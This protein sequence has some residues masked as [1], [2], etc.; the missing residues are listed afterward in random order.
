MSNLNVRIVRLEPMRVASFYGFGKTPENEAHLSSQA[1]LEK[2]GLK[3]NKK[4]YRHFGFNNPDPSHGSPNYGYEIWI[5]VPDDYQDDGSA[6]IKDFSGGLFAVT[7]CEGLHVIGQ[8]WQQL[9]IWRDQSQYKKG[10]YKFC[11][12]EL[13]VDPFSAQGEEGYKFDLYLSIQE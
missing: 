7:H 10:I 1:W 9:V 5:P 11:F 13:L 12:E 8:R 3:G 2:M 4:N 6:E